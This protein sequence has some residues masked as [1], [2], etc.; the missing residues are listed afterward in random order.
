LPLIEQ[1]RAF[2]PGEAET[3]LAAL[4]FQ[5][6]NIRASADALEK[7]FERFRENPWALTKYEK[8]ALALVPSVATDAAIAR[9]LFDALAEPFANLA[10]NELRLMT[11]AGLAISLPARDTCLAALEAF[12]RKT[13]WNERFLQLQRDCYQL[14]HDPR[15]ANASRDFSE[16]LAHDPPSTAA[17]EHPPIV[18]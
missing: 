2:Q 6:S 17:A 16:F 8:A 13:P 9:R 4:R 15:L 11:R 7:A 12:G 5:Q 18:R 1:L 10:V 14:N 3:I